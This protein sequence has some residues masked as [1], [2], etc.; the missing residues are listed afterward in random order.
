M[1]L[2]GDPSSN[3]EK[4]PKILVVRAKRVEDEFLELLNDANLD[5]QS[6]PIMSIKPLPASKLVQDVIENFEHYHFAIFISGNA[7][8]FGVSS[9]QHSWPTLPQG[10]QYLCVG[11]NT[12]Q[13]LSK[14]VSNVASPNTMLTTEGLLSMPQLKLL[15]DKKVAI[16]RGKGGREDLTIELK[17][18]GAL[19][20]VCEL[21]QRFIDKT[22]QALARTQL[23]LVD[24]L[25]ESMG[26]PPETSVDRICVIVP[27]ARVAGIARGLG[28]KR[29]V[30]A[31]SALPAAM[32]KSTKDALQK[33]ELT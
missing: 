9:L 24:C 3:C 27:S 29:V 5:F 16:F 10:V 14:Y 33:K 11:E 20:S 21:Y 2:K 12:R 28:Y 32:L 8:K 4:R 23:P 1:T 6:I 25:V 19:V 18:R 31:E 22:K 30:V 13:L 7:V 15:T 26:K 17:E